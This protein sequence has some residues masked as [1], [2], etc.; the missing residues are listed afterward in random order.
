MSRVDSVQIA[1][2]KRESVAREAIWPLM[3]FPFSD[4]VELAGKAG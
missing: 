3:L 2:Q 4:G 1:V